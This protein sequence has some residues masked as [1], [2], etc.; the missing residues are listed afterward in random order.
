MNYNFLLF[1]R[2]FFSS[3]WWNQMIQTKIRQKLMANK[4]NQIKNNLS[5]WIIKLHV[6]KNTELILQWELLQI[7]FHSSNLN[8]SHK[9]WSIY[10]LQ[11]ILVYPIHISQEAN[12]DNL[13]WLEI[14]GNKK[15]LFSSKGFLSLT[16][17]KSNLH[18]KLPKMQMCRRNKPVGWLLYGRHTNYIWSCFPN[19][20]FNCDDE[21]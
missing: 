17:G 7:T 9:I 13:V 21:D 5:L 16:Q 11:M 6:K 12:Y 4:R 3:Q 2:K 14:K 8:V 19:N 20:Y 1:F 15:I 10:L 18:T